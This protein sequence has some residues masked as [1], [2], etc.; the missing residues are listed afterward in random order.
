MRFL[1][2]LGKLKQGVKVGTADEQL[3]HKMDII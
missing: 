2:K 3:V 1:L